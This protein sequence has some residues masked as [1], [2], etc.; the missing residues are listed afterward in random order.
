[1]AAGALLLAACSGDAGTST[2]A[3]A[4][5]G[6][7]QATESQGGDGISFD[8]SGVEIVTTSTLASGL[9]ASFLRTVELMEEWGASVENVVLSQ[10]SGLDAI[11]AGESN[12][13]GTHDADELIIGVSGGED[14]IGIGSAKSKMD[15]VLVAQ[16]E[17]ES[18]EDLAGTT[19]ATSGPAGFN[20]LLMRFALEDVGLD[21]DN[22]VELAQIGSSG[23]RAAALVSGVASSAAL[24]IDDWFELQSQSD[25][26]QILAYFSEVRPEFPNDVYYA[27]TEYWEANPEVA[28]AWACANLEANAWITADKDRYVEWAVERIDAPEESLAE[29]WD[30]ATEVNMWPTN[31]DE[32][33]DVEGVQALA[34]IL[35]E[36]GDISEPVVAEEMIDLSYLEEAAEMGC[37]QG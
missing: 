13:A 9:D 14:M 12:I 28:L 2:A 24:T 15:Y 4:D 1:M 33:L 19:I 30:F 37:G 25:S 26:L 36:I 7:S 6:E 32:I 34:D 18:V 20:T 31:P 29:V 22:D 10:Q 16:D 27:Y 5:A 8:L 35:L 23:D 11:L 21:P 3:S 17:Y